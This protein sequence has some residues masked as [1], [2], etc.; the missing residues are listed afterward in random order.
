MNV[1][2]MNNSSSHVKNF[3]YVK[4]PVYDA[5]KRVMD[6]VCSVS[7]LILLSPVFLGTAL[8]IYIDDPG[9][10]LFKQGRIGKGGKPSKIYKQVSLYENGC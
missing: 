3:D 1:A 7:G 8:F 6:V 9:P 4:K 5:A 10:V 2:Y